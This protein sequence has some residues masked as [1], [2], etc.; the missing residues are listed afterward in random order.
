MSLCLESAGFLILVM[1]H[2]CHTPYIH[3]IFQGC[4]YFCLLVWVHT[5]PGSVLYLHRCA[6]H[7][8][9]ETERMLISYDDL[10]MVIH[11]HVFLFIIQWNTLIWLCLV[12]DFTADVFDIVLAESLRVWAVRTVCLWF[13]P[14]KKFFRHSMIWSRTSD[15]PTLSWNM[16]RNR[17]NCVPWR[18]DRTSSNR[19]W[20]EVWTSLRH[21]LMFSFKAV[22]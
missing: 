9:K 2:Y 18:T 13:C 3:K 1:S 21:S 14:L 12:S 16:R 20:A 11:F 22:F 8:F 4:D 5:H 6:C 19:R 10:D 15:C 17:F 7:M